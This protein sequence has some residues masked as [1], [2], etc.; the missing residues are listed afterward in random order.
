MKLSKGVSSVIR[1]T[2]RNRYAF[3]KKAEKNNKPV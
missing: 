3:C 2:M 1:L